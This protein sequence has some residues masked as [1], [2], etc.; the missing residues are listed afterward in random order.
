[1]FVD[2]RTRTPRRRTTV[3]AKPRRLQAQLRN[4]IVLTGETTNALYESSDKTSLQFEYH[5]L[6][7]LDGSMHNK[8]RC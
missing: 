5:P 3:K 6:Q 1:M 2:Q 7:L 8:N 4:L